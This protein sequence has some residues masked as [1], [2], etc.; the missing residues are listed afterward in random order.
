MICMLTI[1][2]QESLQ[3]GDPISIRTRQQ[4]CLR[5]AR[6]DARREFSKAATGLRRERPNGRSA[7]LMGRRSGISYGKAN[8]RAT[9]LA[10]K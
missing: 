1:V 10:M 7:Y 9:N 3:R 6:P 8:E 4:E 2:Q 5:M